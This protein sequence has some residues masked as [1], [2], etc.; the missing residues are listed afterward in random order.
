[1]RARKRGKYNFS[2]FSWNEKEK[3]NIRVE[4]MKFSI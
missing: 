2:L 4:W 1:M 3:E